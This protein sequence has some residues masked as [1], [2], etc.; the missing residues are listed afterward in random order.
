MRFSAIILAL[1]LSATA[2]VGVHAEYEPHECSNLISDRGGTKEQFLAELAALDKCQ[3][4]YLGVLSIGQRAAAGQS[5]VRSYI[6]PGERR[7]PLFVEYV[8]SADGRLWVDVRALAPDRPRLTATVTEEAFSLV[9]T[10]WKKQAEI[11]VAAEN[12]HDAEKDH[13]S[14]PG[15][16][17]VCIPRWAATVETAQAGRVERVE[18]DS[19]KEWEFQFADFIVSRALHDVGECPNASATSTDDERLLLCIS[20]NR[21]GGPPSAFHP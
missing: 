16:E 20:R 12:Q 4:A 1:L 10:R 5:V 3:R 13:K 11:S 21:S 19:C 7:L 18:L 6:Q 17:T 14:T 15:I 9:Q 2:V 8:R